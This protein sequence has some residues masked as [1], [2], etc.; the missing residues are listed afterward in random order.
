MSSSDESD[1]EVVA[2]RTEDVVDDLN[3]DG[4]NL[5]ASSYHPLRWTSDKKKDE[6]ILEASTRAAQLLYKK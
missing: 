3:Y 5:T 6:V 2:T 1:Q 4:Y